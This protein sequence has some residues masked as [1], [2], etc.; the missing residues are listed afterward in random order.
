MR[1]PVK[2]WNELE[3]I[4]LGRAHRRLIGKKRQNMKD[5]PYLR[6]SSQ[7][8]GKS[9]PKLGTLLMMDSHRPMLQLRKWIK[10]SYKK[11]LLAFKIWKR[12]SEKRFQRCKR[13]F[14][15]V[16]GRLKRVKSRFWRCKGRFWR[17]KGRFWR[18]KGRFQIWITA[19]QDSKT[20]LAKSKM[21]CLERIDTNW[22]RSKILFCYS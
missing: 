3:C 16:K 9:S 4:K 17:C 13:R 2:L 21:P 6:N 5:F 22:N 15:R 1:L 11:Y 14:W 7:E 18:C 8:T 20:L 12:V 10:L 19:F